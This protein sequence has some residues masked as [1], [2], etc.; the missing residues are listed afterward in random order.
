MNASPDYETMRR[1][2]VAS[3]LRTAAVDDPRVIAAMGRVPREAFLPVDARRYAYRD[4]VQPLPGGRGFNAPVA[5]GRLLTQARITPEDR[6]LLIGAATGYAAAVLAGLA[7]TV[8]AVEEDP[9]LAAEARAAL[10]AYPTVTVVEGPL[11][12][13][14]PAAGPYDLLL[15]DGAV[16]DVPAALV[17]QL[18]LDGRI[19][20]GLVDRGVTRLASGSRSAGGFGLQHFADVEAAL[21]PG[22][23]RPRAFTF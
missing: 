1:A 8:V 2:M 6:V 4:T 7:G 22:F 17:A 23:A 12:A 11:T 14:A 15:I 20:T 16:E 18:T 13:G 21:L 5:T 3:Q 10:A 9:A 19:V